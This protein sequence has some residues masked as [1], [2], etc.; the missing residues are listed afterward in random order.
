MVEINQCGLKR[1]GTMI[2]DPPRTLNM[3]YGR[4]LDRKGEPARG[5]HKILLIGDYSGAGQLERAGQPARSEN[6]GGN[7]EARTVQ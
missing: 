1:A 4:V 3:I 2:Y 7:L 5:Y 6:G